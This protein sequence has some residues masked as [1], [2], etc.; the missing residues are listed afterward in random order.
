[1]KR[2]DSWVRIALVCAAGGAGVSDA[3][4][5]S[6]LAGAIIGIVLGALANLTSVL[7]SK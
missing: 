2:I 5:Y 1:M 3:L 6:S 7:A 4:G